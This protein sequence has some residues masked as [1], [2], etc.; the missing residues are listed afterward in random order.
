VAIGLSIDEPEISWLG[1]L[2]EYYSK[3]DGDVKKNGRN[4][5]EERGRLK[6]VKLQLN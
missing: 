1:N 4:R 6:S 3:S 2:L 5:E